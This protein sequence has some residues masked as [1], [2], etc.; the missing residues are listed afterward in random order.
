MTTT[1]YTDEALETP[2]RLPKKVT[3]PKAQWIEK[4][5]GEFAH[6]QRTFKAESVVPGK[7]PKRFHVY[8][9]QSVADASDFSCGIVYQSRDGNR[10]VLARYNGSSHEHGIDIRYE[11]HIHRTTAA[12]IAAN[13]KPDSTAE[14]TDRYSTLED[15]LE[16]LIH[17]Y[18]ITGIDDRDDEEIRDRQMDLFNG[19]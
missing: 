16:C 14:A 5:G 10:L 15:A 13:K 18:C 3:N 11:P 7:Q 19:A 8:L 2:Q 17:D 12:A 6:R 9:R 1:H 4:P